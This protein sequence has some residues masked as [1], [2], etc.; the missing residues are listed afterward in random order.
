MVFGEELKSTGGSA[1]AACEY[2]VVR[3]EGLKRLWIL[4]SVGF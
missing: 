1:W 2:H 4:V 3:Y